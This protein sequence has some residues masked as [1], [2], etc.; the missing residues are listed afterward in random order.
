MNDEAFLRS[1]THQV[2]R[3]EDDLKL[4]E[5]G[6][7]SKSVE[8]DSIVMAPLDRDMQRLQNDMALRQHLGIGRAFTGPKGV[9]ADRKFHR[10]QECARA[11]QKEDEYRDRISKSAL[12]SG[13]LERQ[14]QAESSNTLSLED[15]IYFS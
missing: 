11:K 14:I 9:I 15:G 3:D 13:W 1:I 5:S 7:D 12:S 2:N 10:Q 4:H 8:E 6:S